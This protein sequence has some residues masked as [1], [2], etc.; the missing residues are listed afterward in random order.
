MTAPGKDG[1]PVHFV[2]M[3]G[4]GNDYVYVDGFQEEVRDPA[5]LARVI[6]DRHFGVGGDGLILIL[7]PETSEGDVRMQMFNADGSEAEMCGNG[8]RCVAKYAVDHGPV[9][10]GREVVKVETL[11]G[12]KT[13]G[14][15]RDD[16]GK[17]V[18]ARVDMGI[19][20]FLRREIP[21]AGPPDERAVDVPLAVGGTPY[22]VTALS[23]GN[24]HCVVFLPSV[25]ELKLEEVGPRF[26]R[27][28]SFPQRVNAEFC[29]VIDGQTLEMRV[30]ERGSGETL[31]CGTGASAAAVAAAVNGHT[32]RRV[33]IHL[34]GGTLFLEWGADDHVYLTGP[35]VEVFSGEWP[36][37][38]ESPELAREVR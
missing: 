18:A 11:A 7:P 37:P 38:A 2:K 3:Q 15:T 31:A 32:G 22:R 24:P 4:A 30:W 1:R 16:S 20:R 27:H 35:A 8:V 10:A 5:R 17:V 26:E 13:I 6:A 33:A 34:R 12:L 19:P 14:L 25:A 28:P 23:L 9:P 36:W 21:M 29:R